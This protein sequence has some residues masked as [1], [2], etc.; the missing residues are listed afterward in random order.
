MMD[1]ILQD[2]VNRL[3][4][5][6]S[7][8]RSSS[9]SAEPDDDGK[10][11]D[12]VSSKGNEEASG[13]SLRR[14]QLKS[15]ERTGKDEV[16]MS[17]A[18]GDAFDNYLLHLRL[19]F[20]DLLKYPA[21][22]TAKL[23]I[24]TQ[25]PRRA[26][27]RSRRSSS[28]SSTSA[29]AAEDASKKKKRKTKGKGKEKEKEKRGKDEDKG[30]EA[31]KKEKFRTGPC[32][33]AIPPIVKLVNHKLRKGEGNAHLFRV[34]KMICEG[35]FL[36]DF[37]K[38]LPAAPKA[39]LADSTG[40]ASSGGE[41]SDDEAC[42]PIERS[43]VAVEVGE[44]VDEAK[45]QWTTLMDEGIPAESKRCVV[46]DI[47]ELSE[48]EGYYGAYWF[49]EFCEA[50]RVRIALDVSRLGISKE[51]A[52]AWSL[53][54]DLCIVLSM[55]FPKWYTRSTGRPAGD[56]VKLF[57]GD[58]KANK[59]LAFGSGK[60]KEFM[61]MATAFGLSWMVRDRLTNG[62][63][64]QWPPEMP[65][66]A[67]PLDE[68][69]D[70]PKEQG[71]E[72]K[73]GKSKKKG[74]KKQ[75]VGSSLLGKMSFSSLMRGNKDKEVEGVTKVSG[76]ANRNYLV[77]ILEHIER[78]IATCTTSCMI[79]DGP[80]EYGGSKP[81][82]CDKEL[83]VYK[84]EELG[85]GADIAAEIRN[86]PE[87]VDLLIS[88]AYAS[89]YQSRIELFFPNNVRARV[90]DGDDVMFQGSTMQ[91][92][93]AAVQKVL[94]ALPSV[95]E[96]GQC[97]TTAELKAKLD[98]LH[99]LCYPLM[100]W[101]I[102]SNRSHLRKLSKS[103]LISQ[104][105]TEH[106]Y[107]LLSSSPTREAAFRKQKEQFGSY[108]MFHGSPVSN[109]HSILRQGLRFNGGTG[110][111]ASGQAIWMASAFST[112][113]GYCM[114]GGAINGWPKSMFGQGT[115]Y[116][117]AILEIA[118]DA[119]KSAVR[120][121]GVNVIADTSIIMPRFFLVFPGTMPTSNAISDSIPVRDIPLEKRKTPTTST[122]GSAS[123]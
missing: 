56:E 1:D 89:A 120:G 29:A 30:K 117:M 79:C 57:Q 49:D 14:I 86:A 112:S 41:I 71:E 40:G 2:H 12:D 18:C 91:E 22:A 122:S 97:Q 3:F 39:A 52:L 54:K 15:I 35:L 26:T 99:V 77:R 43:D 8:R 73:K 5:I 104:V 95:K 46:R 115:L 10:L 101:L 119:S 9:A 28:A 38:W 48:I 87:I 74:K 31:E 13:V 92:K 36:E 6:I 25:S 96:M 113:Y 11:K 51:Q 24:T 37:E 59:D 75:Q 16:L 69:L 60:G 93:T 72:K 50:I 65:A 118:A 64:A 108:Y 63:F 44:H 88:F 123:S 21:H 53:D 98:Q 85:L 23:H 67:L 19:T 121:A 76:L 33:E 80:L 107:M 45:S 70:S 47:E 42:D 84:Y 100:R 103:E 66:D 82:V 106:Q 110:L 90:K 17:I 94:A 61:S 116:C 102:T 114:K 32:P 20:A 27:T 105:P 83:C 68:L 78:T 7:R 58:V 62:L 4:S 111:G 81:V 55:S 109:W 34:L